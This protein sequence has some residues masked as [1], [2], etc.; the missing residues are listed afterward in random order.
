MKPT[1]AVACLLAAIPLL[2]S[3]AHA[4]GGMQPGLWELAITVD[5]NGRAQTVPASRECISQLDIDGGNRTLPRPEG[6][7]VSNVERSSDRAT[8]DLACMQDTLATRG[9]A[10]LRFSGDRYDG[11]VEM[12]V[13]EKGGQNAPLVMTIAAKRV[14]DCSK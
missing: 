13:A 4:A 3:H 2:P 6:C 1:L 7:S 10:D 9:K 11:K 12:T 5:V 14:G 8:Y